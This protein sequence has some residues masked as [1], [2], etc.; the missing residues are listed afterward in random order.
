MDKKKQEID[1]FLLVSS[2]VGGVAL[3]NYALSK[4]SRALRS[5]FGDGLKDAIK[6]ATRTTA[7]AFL[8]G[9]LTTAVLSSATASSLLVLAFVQSGDMTLRQSLGIGLGIGLGSTLNAHLLAFSLHRYAMAMV[10]AGYSGSVWGGQHVV[11]RLCEALM[12]LGLLF[13]STSIVSKA[14]SPLKGFAP[15]VNFLAKMRNP[16]LAMLV[17]A[18]SAVAFQSSNT[19]IAIAIMLAKQGF[20]SSE[21]GVYFV[22]GANVGTSV[23]PVVAALGKRREALRVA[24]A[25]LVMKVIGIA[26]L[27]PFLS[28]FVGVVQWSTLPAQ[29]QAEDAAYD[30]MVDRGAFDTCVFVS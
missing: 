8:T 5:A 10:A 30:A 21:T 1:W 3:L 7:L 29:S 16:W 17:S 27:M 18:V 25:Y 4:V 24:V 23:T 9:T 19:V 12:G 20:L 28:T 2:A 14:V 6:R 13:Q 26:T 15:F 11:G 22:L